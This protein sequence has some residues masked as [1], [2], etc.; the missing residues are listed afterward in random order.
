MNKWKRVT[1]HE[2]QAIRNTLSTSVTWFDLAHKRLD[3]AVSAAYGWQSDPSDEEIL[4]KLLALNL[5]RS[6][7]AGV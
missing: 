5:E 7:A 2:K 6:K 1:A 3:A 4:E